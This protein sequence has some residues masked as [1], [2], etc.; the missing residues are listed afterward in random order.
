MKVKINSRIERV[1]SSTIKG[2]TIIS[3]PNKDDV[4]YVLHAAHPEPNVFSRFFCLKQV[5]S[6][7]EFIELQANM[8]VYIQ[9][10]FEVAEIV[11][12]EF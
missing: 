9:G 5:G 6:T 1:H 4:Y 7:P 12:N 2:G 11:L 10:R 8:D 3:I